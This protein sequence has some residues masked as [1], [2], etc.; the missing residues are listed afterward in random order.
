MPPAPGDLAARAT[1]GGASEAEFVGR[2][3]ASATPLLYPSRRDTSPQR[4]A[5]I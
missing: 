5:P 1:D 4:E 3:L 2:R